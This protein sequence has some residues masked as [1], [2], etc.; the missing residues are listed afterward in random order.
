MHLAGVWGDHLSLQALVNACGLTVHCISSYRQNW[1]V[2][3]TP[4]DLSNS[5]LGRPP[6]WDRP[7][8]KKLF[9]SYLA[10]EHFDSVVT[11]E[12][13]LKLA[14]SNQTQ[15][16]HDQARI[17]QA[18]EAGKDLALFNGVNHKRATI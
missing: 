9:I 2:V 8:R 6:L 17:V 16:N 14:Q 13:A 4:Q 1:H 10:P 12:H 5:K 11:A 15:S 18:I 7:G 3:H